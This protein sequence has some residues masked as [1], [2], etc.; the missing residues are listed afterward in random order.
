MAKEQ[1]I[2]DAQYRKG[3]SIAFFN[4]T[5]ASIELVKNLPLSKE[6]LKKQITEYRDWFL[7]EHK[8]YYEK[9]VAVIGKN[10][11]VDETVKELRTAKTTEE[12]KTLW[13]RL[14]QDE[15]QDAVIIVEVNKLKKLYEKT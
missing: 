12:L 4:A 2:K 13:L 15:R 11:D 10:Y 7:E 9:V 6:E 1:K 8:E 14:S 5:N 3:L